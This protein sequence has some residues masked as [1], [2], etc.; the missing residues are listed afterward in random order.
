MENLILEW[1]NQFQTPFPF[2]Y[3]Q[4][5]PWSGYGDVETGTLLR[6]QQVKMLEI[7]KTGMVVISDVVEDPAELHPRFKKPV[8]ERLANLALGDHYGKKGIIYKTPLY[9]SM[10]IEKKAIRISFENIPSG[11]MIKGR[12]A[13]DF[14]IA[15]EDQKFYPAK[16]K[17][18][19]NTV[20]VSAK[21]VKAPVAV[22]FGW[23]NG[24]L[25]NLF[26]REGL[27]PVPGFRTDDWPVLK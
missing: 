17:I 12:E 9:K 14:T 5:A 23:R 7:P 11:L 1:R 20:V 19:G 10:K 6:E 13:T 24:A 22:R 21:E 25:P 8:G 2:Y 3:V 26:S 15:G 16:A 27:L 4:I 18:E